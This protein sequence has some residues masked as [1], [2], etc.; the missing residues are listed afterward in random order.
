MDNKN[1]ALENLVNTLTRVSASVCYDALLENTKKISNLGIAYK[2]ALDMNGKYWSEMIK[3]LV[4]AL[5]Q[6]SLLENFDISAI[7][8]K[9]MRDMVNNIS[10]NCLT[11]SYK[12][13][14]YDFSKLFEVIQQSNIQVEEI[15]DLNDDEII[16]K[17]ADEYI[18]ATTEE[19]CNEK[20]DKKIDV[21]EFRE[22]ILFFIAIMSFVLSVINI[23]ITINDSSNSTT[24][25]NNYYVNVQQIDARL[26]NG[27]SYRIVNIDDVIVRKNHDCSSRVVG[28]LNEG[29]VVYVSNKYK[30]WI[31]INWKD[32]EDNY[33]TGW[34]QNY[35]VTEF[36]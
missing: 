24:E 3:K 16:E 15:T 25:V 10:N 23:K 35:K 18:E 31:E 4:P 17:I 19:I 11:S 33:C 5:N 9:E 21:K 2:L 1:D 20:P 12:M 28:H 36:K 14:K 29:Q 22:W 13:D 30:K 7:L 34:V 26:L 8:T 6:L 27:L 32:E